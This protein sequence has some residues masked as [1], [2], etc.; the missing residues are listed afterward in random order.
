MSDRMWFDL[1]ARAPGI[2]E[3]LDRISKGMTLSLAI[4]A[5]ELEK[6]LAAILQEIQRMAKT[7]D[8]VL[9]DTTAQTTVVKSVVSLLT[10]IAKQLKD[11]IASGNP[12]KIQA[13]ADALEANTQ[14][15][16]DAV[17]ANTPGGPVTPPSGP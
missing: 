7:I 15:L 5:P 4:N 9:A 1:E 2:E 12:A 8:D 14:A 16:A 10:D 13:A 6:Y 11:A 17:A 3:R